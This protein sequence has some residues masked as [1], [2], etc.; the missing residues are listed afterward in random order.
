MT[1]PS[2]GDRWKKVVLVAGFLVF[3][4]LPHLPLRFLSQASRGWEDVAD[5]ANVMSQIAEAS[6]GGLVYQNPYAPEG[7]PRLVFHP[8]F[9]A[10]GLFVRAGLAADWVFRIVR[11]VGA[12]AVALLTVRM[13]WRYAP[14]DP[15]I[16]T[17]LMLFGSGVGPLA[18][19]VDRRMPLPES[20]Q[21]L[22]VSL[23]EAT[24]A[25][26]CTVYAHVAVALAML[27]A[28]HACWLVAIATGSRRAAWGAAIWHALLAFTHPF[29]VVPVVLVVVASIA[30]LAAR[31]ESVVRL[32][33]L[34]LPV[35]AAPA[36]GVAYFKWL[37]VAHPELANAVHLRQ[38]PYPLMPM[39][40]TVGATVAVAIAAAVLHRGRR[41]VTDVYILVW[42]CV[43][44]F[45]ATIGLPLVSFE[46]RLIMGV[47]APAALLAG[48]L[49]A[50]LLGGRPP[51]RALGVL[52][53]LS[54]VAGSFVRQ[55]SL[56]DLVPARVVAKGKQRPLSIRTADALAD[57]T[58]L[59]RELR[60]RLQRGDI[61]LCPA[62]IGVAVPWRTDAKPYIGHRA[63]TPDYERR[64]GELRAFFTSMS[65][66]ERRGFLDARHITWILQMAPL[67]PAELTSSVVE[68]VA[69]IGGARLYRAVR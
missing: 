56:E 54:C 31:G 10:A 63:Y 40:G 57:P 2:P 45:A 27:L 24:T 47:L 6:R 14:G 15:A 19:L 32:G 36:P 55:L 66:A 3:V 49:V 34:A 61:I 52:L 53:L 9:L 48:P 67:P 39:L 44:L 25:D 22:R 65:D 11:M 12:L 43:Q 8:L 29:D 41:G 51:S 33:L 35:L 64:E 7:S 26:T 38:P 13:S 69:E 20:L 4:D 18:A 37:S 46:R 17:V 59:W 58:P 28:V 60:A 50:R 62:G 5:N 21:A 30:A 16:A 42:L 1:G 68:K 23:P